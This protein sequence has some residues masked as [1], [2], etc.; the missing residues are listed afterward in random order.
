[1][2]ADKINYLL[3]QEGVSFVPKSFDECHFCYL[4]I[5]R[6]VSFVPN[7][8]DECR[9]CYYLLIYGREFHLC[10]KVP[11]SAVFVI[12]S[13][14]REFHF[15]FFRILIHSLNI[16]WLVFFG[17]KFCTI[18]YCSIFHLMKNKCLVFFIIPLKGCCKML[19]VKMT[20]QKKKKKME[21]RANVPIS[22]KLGP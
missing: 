10:R 16:L 6:G 13:D 20:D 3:I 22:K 15:S 1:M 2:W 11:M 4:L 21:I 7:S 18:N 12:C 19:S 17:I 9:F 8:S 14:R 5:Q